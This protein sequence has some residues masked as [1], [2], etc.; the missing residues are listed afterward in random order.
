[1]FSIQSIG[2]AASA[3]SEELDDLGAGIFACL[4]KW[5]MK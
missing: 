1:M 3:A 4:D 5:V 2:F